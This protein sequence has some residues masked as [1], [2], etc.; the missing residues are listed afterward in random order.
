MESMPKKRAGYRKVKSPY[1]HGQ[2][3]HQAFLLR[4]CILI[5]DC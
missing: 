3:V 5:Q 2:V 4:E 1:R